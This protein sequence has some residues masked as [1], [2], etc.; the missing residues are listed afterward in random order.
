MKLTQYSDLGLR[1]L[2]YLALRHDDTVTIQEVSVRFAI[3]K[4]HLVKIS[5]QLTKSGLI[6]S[7]RGRNG[8]VRLANSPEN[9]SVEEAL[10]ATEDNFDLVEC[11]SENNHCVITEVCRLSKV[12][13]NAREAFFDVLRQVTLADL[14]KS[15]KTLES[16]LMPLPQRSTVKFYSKPGYAARK[17]TKR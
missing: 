8:G 9:I 6:E 7:I 4:N 16:A 3:S 14:V 12:L 11:F 5:H 15:R 17:K 1:L 13:D 10:L 2:M